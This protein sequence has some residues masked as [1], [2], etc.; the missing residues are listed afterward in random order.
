MKILYIMSSYNIY[1]G[2]PKKTLDLM[3]FF[4]T[5]SSLYVYQNSYPEFKPLFEKTGGNIF[6]GFYENNILKHLFKLLKIIDENNIKIIQTQFSKGELLAFFVKLFRPKIKI[7]CAFVGPFKP[8]PF[9]SFITPLFYKKFDQ[10]VYISKY[11][12]NTK[13]IQFNT[14]KE[15]P[16]VIIPNGSEK[17]IDTGDQTLVMPSHSL[18]DI[19]GLVDWKNIKVLI[20]AMNIL[21]NKKNNKSIHLFVAGE[22]PERQN[23]ES[24]ITKFNLNE[25]VNLIGYHKNVGKMLNDCDIFVHPAYAE[26]FGIVIPEAMLAK[27]PIIISNAGALP[28]HIEHEVSGLIVDPFNAEAWVDAILRLIENPTFAKELGAN[29]QKQAEQKF[30]FDIYTKNYEELYY[31]ILA[32]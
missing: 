32:N 25:Y 5:K 24:L 21:V 2:T 27:K 14:L 4:G 9:K 30:T 12:K 16:S 23:L 18:F 11:V 15:K 7:V 26:G 10:F 28:E 17:R 29:S 31:S 1:G 3:K 22:G 20:Q 6:E 8:S 19:A 13:E